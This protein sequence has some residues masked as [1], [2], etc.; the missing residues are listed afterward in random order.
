MVP[1]TARVTT[2][3]GHA[4]KRLAQQTASSRAAPHRVT[5]G[6][7]DAS[8][9]GVRAGPREHQPYWHAAGGCMCRLRQT[10]GAEQTSC[11]RGLIGSGGLTEVDLGFQVGAR[12][13]GGQRLL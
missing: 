11:A 12:G 1:A 8:T 2:G 5:A 10:K 7:S 9:Q 3:P 6:L 13:G 4:R